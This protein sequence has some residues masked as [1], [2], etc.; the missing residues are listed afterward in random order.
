MESRR[1]THSRT[2]PRVMIFRALIFGSAMLL[3]VS[4]WMRD[5]LPSPDKL[6]AAVSSPG[7]RA[8]ERAPFRTTAGAV[9]YTVRP[10]FAYDL[11]GLVVS[12]HNADTWWDW[13]HK[14]WGDS[15]NSTD[16]CVVWGGNAQRGGTA[17]SAFRAAS[18]S[19]T[20]RRRRAKPGTRL[21][22]TRS[23]TITSS[24]TTR[25]LPRC[26]GP[27]ASATRSTSAVTSPNIASP[28]IRVLPR[29]QHDAQGHRQRRVRNRIRDGGRDHPPGQ[30]RLAPG[31]HGRAWTLVVSVMVWLYLEFFGKDD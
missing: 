25:R 21:T 24:P 5:S 11:S 30:P 9:E 29:H 28:G 22:S 14:A 7:Q 18:S 20:G 1:G 6:D 10:V 4:W 23:R 27:R 15:L 17:T 12:K 2:T 19:A 31:V 8:T 3:A 26:E 13:V 16:L